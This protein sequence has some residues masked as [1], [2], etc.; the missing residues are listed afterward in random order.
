MLQLSTADSQADSSLLYT[1]S[2]ITDSQADSTHQADSLLLLSLAITT[3][4]ISI[5]TFYSHVYEHVY[6]SYPF[7]KIG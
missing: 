1:E 3:W 2:S 6:K 4:E 7:L 5:Y